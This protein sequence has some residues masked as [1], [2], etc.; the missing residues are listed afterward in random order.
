MYFTIRRVPIDEIVVKI[1]KVLLSLQS[2]KNGK[3]SLLES[4]ISPKLIKI[5]VIID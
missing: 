3:S 5:T 1:K 4:L 2:Y